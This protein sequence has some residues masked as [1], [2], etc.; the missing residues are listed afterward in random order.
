MI[1]KILL[2][3]LL[4]TSINSFSEVPRYSYISDRIE[5]PIRANKEFGNNILFSLSSG[6]RI[7][8]LEIHEDG[9]SKIKYGST[10]GWMISRYIMNSISSQ[11]RIKQLENENKLLN[12][13]LKEF[14]K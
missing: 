1:K 14:L 5:I 4:A 2:L 13:R 3:A 12:T 6:E 9:W 10:E 8:V 7:E 11:E